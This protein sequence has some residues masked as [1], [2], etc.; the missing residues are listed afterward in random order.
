VGPLRLSHPRLAT[1]PAGT[2]GPRS[3]LRIKSV[4]EPIAEPDA[5]YFFL[6]GGQVHFSAGC[7]QPEHT[8]SLISRP[9]FLQG[10]QPHV[11]HITVSFRLRTHPAAINRRLGL[12]L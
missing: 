8:L 10:P 12:T 3:Y 9:H 1:A 11:W 5:P 2:R 7:L 4:S 6:I